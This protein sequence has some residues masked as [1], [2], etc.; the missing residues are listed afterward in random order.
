MLIAS[1]SFSI[2]LFTDYYMYL[3]VSA[4]CVAV[5][6]SFV[7][8]NL[9]ALSASLELNEGFYAALIVQTDLTLLIR[10]FIEK[11]KK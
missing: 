9:I 4:A 1:L 8:H 3:L 10:S 6:A 5:Q 11:R 7:V 2:A